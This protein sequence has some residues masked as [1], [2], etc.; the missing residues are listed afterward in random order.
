MG[1]RLSLTSVGRLLAELDL[2]PQKPLRR[3]GRPS[4]SFPRSGNQR[5]A[6]LLTQQWH[7]ESVFRSDGA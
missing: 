3:G 5:P 7:T 2:T 4:P 1:V 6:P